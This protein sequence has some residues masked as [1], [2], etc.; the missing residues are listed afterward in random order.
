[1]KTLFWVLPLTVAALISCGKKDSGGGGDAGGGQA[2]V[3]EAPTPA[4][5]PAPAPVA[6]ITPAASCVA[7]PAADPYRTWAG[8]QPWGFYGYYGYA[9][10]NYTYGN[11]HGISY[12]YGT[13]NGYP[14]VPPGVPPQLYTNNG[15]CGCPY[16]MMPVCD[17]Q[18]G[19]G[20][21]ANHYYYNH[22]AVAWGWRNGGFYHNGYYP[23][24]Y[25]PQNGCYN[26]IMQTCRIGS[27][28]CGGYGRCQPS[29]SGSQ[30]GVCV[31]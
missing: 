29:M 5:Q 18:Y 28:D 23:V 1:M 25:Y 9:G 8:Y 7:S 16:G 11:W 26:Q 24:G 22:Q 12:W 10:Y 30:I 15:F 2:P 21:V 3:A 4:P 13:S 20:C 31:R 6:P 19:M 14:P 27:N 17:S